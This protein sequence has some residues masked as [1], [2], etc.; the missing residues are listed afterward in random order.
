MAGNKDGFEPGRSKR[1]GEQIEQTF[2]DERGAML[3][4]PIAAKSLGLPVSQIA[5]A[6]I[7]LEEASKVE[8]VATVPR[9]ATTERLYR[10]VASPSS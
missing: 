10:S 4:A 6:F 7:R 5:Y 9:G 2:R 3:S 1:I 8:R